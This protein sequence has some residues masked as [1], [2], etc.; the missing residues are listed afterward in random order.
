M[1]QSYLFVF[2][3]TTSIFQSCV[4]LKKFKDLDSDYLSANKQL[5]IQKQELSDFKLINTELNEN[6]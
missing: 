5:V 2:L 3:F 6:V 4:S 1:K